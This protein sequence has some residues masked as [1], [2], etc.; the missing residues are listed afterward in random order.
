MG[1]VAINL[2]EFVHFYFKSLKFQKFFRERKMHRKMYQGGSSRK[3]GPR[4]AIRELHDEPPRDAQVNPC[5]WPSEEFMVRAGI[6]DKS[7][8]YLCNADLEEFMQD[9]CPQYHYLTDSFVIRFKFT[10]SH[11]SHSVLFDLYDKSYTMDLED[12]T[13]SCKLP[14]WG[15]ASEPRKSEFKDFL[16]SITVG[17][18]REIAQATIGSI[19]F[20]AIHYLLYL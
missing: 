7:D 2:V 15:S 5:E 17:E 6:K 10:S 12:F 1:V 13:T 8:A 3:Q 18:S 9:K 14:Q 20:P 11:N 19:Y 16:A 4:L